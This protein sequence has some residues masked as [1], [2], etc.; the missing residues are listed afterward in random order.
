M[1]SIPPQKSAVVHHKISS[2]SNESRT[3]VHSHAISA[4]AA[5]FLMAG[6][7]HKEIKGLTIGHIIQESMLKTAHTEVGHA[8]AT[9]T[10]RGNGHTCS[11]RPT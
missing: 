5:Q 1:V 4:V 6:S 11:F 7:W 3:Q 9:Q 2:P 8:D 10:T